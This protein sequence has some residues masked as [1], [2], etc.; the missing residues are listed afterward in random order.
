MDRPVLLFSSTYVGYDFLRQIPESP[1]EWNRFE[2]TSDPTHPRLYGCVVYDDLPET[3]RLPCPRS[4]C[5]LV[6]G[7]PPS[8]RTYRSRYTHQFG[9]IRTS[10]ASISHPNKSIGHEGQPWYYGLWAGGIHGKV[11]RFEE[12]AALTP[13][14]KRNRI[15]VIASNK[16]TTPDH[17]ERLRFVEM[18][19]EEFGDQIDVF[20]RGIRTMQDKSE[21]IFPYEYHIVLENDHSDYYVS[22]KLVDSYLGWSYPIYSGSRHADELFPSESFLRIDMYEPNQSIRR[23]RE[24]LENDIARRRLAAVREARERVL[25]QHNLF[26]MVQRHFAKLAPWSLRRG[27]GS[28]LYPKKQAAKQILRRIYEKVLLVEG[29]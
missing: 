5:L 12:I 27:R 28:V 4:H 18:L 6:T 7:E 8:L 19:K 29:G 22:E 16:T 1:V 13:P 2:F 10:H 15:S 11:I 23:I 9:A 21:A 17:R 14:P 24:A 3:L 26:A 20:G 25:H